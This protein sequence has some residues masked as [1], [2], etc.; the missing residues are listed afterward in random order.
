MDLSKSAYAC[1]RGV[2]EAAI[3]KAI[4]TGRITM[5][6]DGT[7]DP[8]KADVEWEQTTIRVKAAPFSAPKAKAT[9]SSK[10]LNDR[11]DALAQSPSSTTY[12]QAKTAHEVLKVQTSK[13]R[14]QSLKGDLIDR[15]QALTHVFQLARALRD[16]WLNWPTRIASVMAEELNVNAHTLQM[17]L[18][19]YV[20]AH[21]LEQGEIKPHFEDT[22]HE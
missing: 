15:K 16:S 9:A 2:S 8:R 21:L 1:H 13:V 14:L 18:D 6:P 11:R 7:I 10:M 3:R 17:T 19:H 22:S 5:N 4:K 12:L 20:R